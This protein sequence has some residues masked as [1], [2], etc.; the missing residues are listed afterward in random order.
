MP[1][2]AHIFPCL[3]R[4]IIPNVKALKS[5]HTCKEDE[6]HLA[7]TSIKK[8]WL[9]NG[10]EAMQIK[11]TEKTRNVTDQISNEPDQGGNTC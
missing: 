11:Y 8:H 3:Q 7:S 6:A 10:L 9:R 4:L 2:A 5:R 1:G